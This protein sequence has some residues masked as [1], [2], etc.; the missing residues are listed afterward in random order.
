MFPWSSAKAHKNPTQS[1]RDLRENQQMQECWDHSSI[2]KKSNIPRFDTCIWWL[3]WHSLFQRPHIPGKDWM[4]GH[5]Q[6]I[7]QVLHVSAFDG[8]Q[9]TSTIR[10]V[11]PQDSYLSLTKRED[12]RRVDLII[13]QK[14]I[15]RN[16]CFFS[17]SPWRYGG[18]L[19]PQNYCSIFFLFL[20][21]LK[22][23]EIPTCI[24]N[25]YDCFSEAWNWRKQFPKNEDKDFRLSWFRCK[26]SDI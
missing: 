25:T 2:L 13:K 11:I 6:T 26:C 7:D 15:L 14:G 4:V 8:W 19:P 1:P 18:V 12:G 17:F 22:V 9:E 3:S 10:G 21:V 24:W 5:S 23:W 16:G 20:E